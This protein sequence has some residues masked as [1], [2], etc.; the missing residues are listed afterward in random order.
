MKF[1]KLS[2]AFITTAVVCLGVIYLT[3]PHRLYWVYRCLDGADLKIACLR[4]QPTTFRTTTL[5]SIYEGTTEDYIDRRV[6]YLGAFEKAE[7]F[8]LRDV[9]AGGVFVDIGAHKGLYS[10]FLSKYQEQ[11]HAFEPFPPVLSEFKR[12]VAANNVKNISIH[13]V[14]IGEKAERLPFESPGSNNMAM[15]SFAFL[16]DGKT[17]DYFEVVTGDEALRNS[18]VT[19]V[20]LIKMDIEGFERPALRGLAQTLKQSRPIVLFELTVR[21]NNPKLFGS[22]A[23]IVNT[24]PSGYKFS[25]IKDLDLYTGAYELIPADSVINFTSKHEQHN[26][27]A[28]PLEKEKRISFRGPVKSN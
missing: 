22:M 15:G 10:L 18:G 13:P 2:L 20:D 12:R 17:H 9:S 27:V 21:A 7:M 24:F 25:V 1:A 28:Y 6:L 19:S 11:V 8:F 3:A 26:I 23:E 5:G 4:G 14:G 16:T